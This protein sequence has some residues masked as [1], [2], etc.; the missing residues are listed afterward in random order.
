MK[1]LIAVTCAALAA[2]AVAQEPAP[3]TPLVTHEPAA[4]EPPSAVS[5]EDLALV[6][7]DEEETVTFVKRFDDEQQALARAEV[8]AARELAEAGQSEAAAARKSVAEDRVT[9]V[10]KLYE[11]VLEHY[12]NNAVLHN[13]YGEL[14]YDVFGQVALGVKEWKTALALDGN[15]GA[16][17]NNLGIHYAHY[18]DYPMALKHMD[19]ALSLD[20]E[21]P[22]YLFNMAQVYLAHTPQVAKIR[23]WSEKKIYRKAMDYSKKAAELAPD[24]YDLQQDYAVNF[25]AAENFEVEAN[26][27]DAAAAWQRARQSAQ[28][29]DQVFY[30]WLNEGRVW[31]R[32][33][34]P[35]L[36][37]PALEQALSLRPESDVA[38]SLLAKAGGPKAAAADAPEPAQEQP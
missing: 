31:L 7:S 10:R 13:G 22:D 32:A 8:E 16:V 38:R 36:A 37:R 19:M 28:R 25:F 2:V 3:D 18:G 29:P 26:W 24:D 21:N 6:L 33:E 17:H 23:K 35:D 20:K 12:P 30:T 1:M 4:V 15:L 5:P 14:L 34:R 11:Q 27:K 9:Q